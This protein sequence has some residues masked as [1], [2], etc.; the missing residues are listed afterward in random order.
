MLRNIHGI[1]RDLRT[2]SEGCTCHDWLHWKANADAA[3]E[4]K[5]CNAHTS[6]NDTF[7]GVRFQCPLK[8]LRAPELASESG[9]DGR[10]GSLM[11]EI[12]SRRLAYILGPCAGLSPEDRGK[13]LSDFTLGKAAMRHELV[14][15][16]RHWE[17]LPWKLIGL[18]HHLPAKAKAVA[19]EAITMFDTSPQDPA[20]HHRLTLAFLRPGSA[21]RSQ[22]E[23]FAHSSAKLDELPDLLQRVAPLA[24]IA[25]AERRGEG[26]HSIIA[27]KTRGKKVSPAYV[28]I[29]LRLP[30]IVRALEDKSTAQQIIEHFEKMRKP[31]SAMINLGMNHHPQLRH[32]R[33]MPKRWWASVRLLEMATY[34]ADPETK[35]HQYEAARKAHDKAKK[36]TKKNAKAMRIN[37]KTVLS[38][39]VVLRT[40][41]IDHC[42]RQMRP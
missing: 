18:A 7:D 40:A 16:M 37:T 20:L 13:V 22:L 32:L 11:E 35:F 23:Q 9:P 39:E 6:Q 41:L 10:I 1:V 24:F 42:Q 28:S 33:H 31:Q 27:K 14:T 2:W 15:K 5:Q 17:V 21:L 36:R 30:M 12:C 34:C 3:E 8:S 38:E 29:T 19:R 26:D 25:V 4:L